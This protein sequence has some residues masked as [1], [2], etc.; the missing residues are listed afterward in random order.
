MKKTSSI[1]TIRR[2]EFASEFTSTSPTVTALIK[3]VVTSTGR[4]WVPTS[5]SWLIYS[6]RVPR[7]M[8][9]LQD[10]GVEIVDSTEGGQTW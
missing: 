5:G 1:V 6:T 9:A 10:A 8:T 2:R 3:R 7:L 4:E